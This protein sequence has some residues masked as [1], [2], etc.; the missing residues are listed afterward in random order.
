VN[1]QVLFLFLPFFSSNLLSL[2]RPG[3]GDYLAESQFRLEFELARLGPNQVDRT[4]CRVFLVRVLF[5]PR[6]MPASTAP[7]ILPMATGFWEVSPI[8]VFPVLMNMVCPPL[9]NFIK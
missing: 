1:L 7:L 4:Q 8:R 3:L 5:L 6:I 9:L 2:E